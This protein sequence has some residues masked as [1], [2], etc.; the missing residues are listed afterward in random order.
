[1]E[2]HIDGADV[3]ELVR[4]TPPP[5]GFEPF[6]VALAAVAAAPQQVFGVALDPLRPADILTA[7]GAS[8]GMPP[9]CPLCHSL[10]QAVFQNAATD[11]L[12]EC[13]YD[14]YEAVYRVR[15]ALWEP[16][17]LREREGWIPP[18][19]G[20]K[21]E[22][23]V[24]GRTAPP[25]TPPAEPQAPGPALSELAPPLTRPDEPGRSRTN[26]DD[27][28]P[29]V[30]DLEW[31]ALAD[32][33]AVTGKTVNAIYKLVRRGRV[34]ARKDEKGRVVVQVDALLAAEDTGG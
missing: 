20:E 11:T 8:A 6:A 22:G 12:F 9:R 30:G 24:P 27:A 34:A 4:T 15:A 16:R 29:S 7:P 31:L 32:A 26:L 5:R 13:L 3:Q 33:A 1:M 10:L 23:A 25:P 21:P 17:P 14:G 19:H 2:T 18:R 28:G